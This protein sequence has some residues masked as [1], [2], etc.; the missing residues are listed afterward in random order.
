MSEPRPHPLA[1]Q[2]VERYAVQQRL[3]RV[4]GLIDSKEI[5]VQLRSH[6][7]KPIFSSEIPARE[8]LDELLAGLAVL[9]ISGVDSAD[10]LEELGVSADAVL[11]VVRNQHVKRYYEKHY[12][13]A[14]PILLRE[15]LEG[16]QRY[17]A[18]LIR[19]QVHPTWTSSVSAFLLLDAVF[20]AL[21][22]MQDFL[23]LL[24]GF[25]V[26]GVR[27]E[28]LYSAVG[29]KLLMRRWLRSGKRTQIL[30]GM[31]DFFSFSE[32]LDTLL[33]QSAETPLLRGQVWLH[34]GYW[35]GGGG[36]RMRSVASRIAESLKE[37][38]AEDAEEAKVAVARADLQPHYEKL[39]VILERLTGPTYPQALFSTFPDELGRWMR[40]AQV[41]LMQDQRVSHY[42][43][44]RREG[45]AIEQNEMASVSP[46]E[47]MTAQWPVGSNPVDSITSGLPKRLFS[48]P[49]LEA[50]YQADS[51][52]LWTFMRP[53][54]RPCLT[55]SMLDD[56]GTL[57]EMIPRHFGPQAVPLDFLVLGSRTSGVFSFGAD[58]DLSQRLIR[59]RDR[60]GLIAYGSRCVEILHRFMDALD[61]P[62]VTVGLVQ[63]QALGGGF[64]ILLS[65]DFIIA[66]RGSTFGL[67][68]MMF[69]MIP[70]MGAHAILSRKL[71]TAVAERMILSNQTY[72]AEAMYEAGIVSQLA[73]P[74]EGMAAAAAFI[75]KSA[76]RHAGL[77]AA[78]RTMRTA[79]PV[80]LEE[81][82]TNVSNW[83]DAAVQLSERDLKLMTRLAAAQARMFRYVEDPTVSAKSS[84]RQRQPNHD[85]KLEVTNLYSFE[86]AKLAK[87]AR[88]R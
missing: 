87:L 3:G 58:L 83:A 12:P 67:P 84:P 16:N 78:R 76:R 81:L 77:V 40:S 73:D 66:E 59:A 20:K 65:L 18:Q 29:S 71:G 17:C 15:S 9:H 51:R 37:L 79:A 88:S 6:L 64:E 45:D 5:K 54:L 4:L 75:E 47:E 62:M 61:L 44:T 28:H 33:A 11:G 34:F 56:F 10:D 85:T 31:Q 24:D 39:R 80:T 57:Q 14:G 41:A 53:P 74:G 25:E 60:D 26:K 42:G 55:T 2:I 30:V 27:L 32:Q 50:S 52:A 72:S 8:N 48:L 22:P 49:E 21:G 7:E 68:E 63:G 23:S 1:P 46:E 70:S 82:R 69:G 35:Y 19:E 13:F 38:V 43:N 36:E 86:L